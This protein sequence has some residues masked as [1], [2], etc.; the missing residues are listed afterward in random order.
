MA[1]LD[2]VI[3]GLTC[4]MDLDNPNDSCAKCPYYRKNA[5]GENDCMRGRL[6]PDAIALL[7]ECNTVEYALSVLRKHGWKETDDVPYPVELLKEKQPRLLTLEEV[8]QADVVW[9]EWTSVDGFVEC[10]MF[11]RVDADG[12]YRF[13]E[14]LGSQIY[15]EPSEYNESWRCWS[16]RPTAEQM[17]ETGWD[18]DGE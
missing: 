3:K 17:Q 4:C 16:A 6:M 14:K 12:D 9:N 1:E 18:G 5:Y 2:N 11:D 7:K 10:M 13:T 15:F 8:K